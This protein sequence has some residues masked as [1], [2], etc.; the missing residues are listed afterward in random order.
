MILFLYSVVLGVKMGPKRDISP[1][2]REY[3]R[4]FY[5]TALLKTN[6]YFLVS[7]KKLSIAMN[8]HP[9]MKES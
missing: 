8:A 6:A 4:L 7:Y 2:N 1:V 3:S 5:A 9:V